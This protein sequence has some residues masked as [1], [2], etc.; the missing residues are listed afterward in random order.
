MK[1][2]LIGYGKMGRA[3]EEAAMQRNHEIIARFDSKHKLDEEI[4]ELADVAIEFSRPELAL[5]HIHACLENKIPVVVGTTGWYEDLKEVE[6][7][8][9]KNK[10]GVFHATNFSLGVNLFFQMN[11]KLAKLMNKHLEYA[12][13][14]EEIH[15]TQKL[16]APSGTAI[17]LAEHVIKKLDDKET[18]V[19]HESQNPEELTI[20]SKRIENV[21]GTHTV[22]YTSAVDSI[23]VTHTAFN[24]K[25]FAEGAVL[26]AEYLVGKTGIHTMDDLLKF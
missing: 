7:A 22:S 17:T 5:D 1:I 24:R 18:W 10:T 13:K 25:G 23:E 19:N 26:A 6:K 4:L 20:I 16:D 8:S 9:K 12:V 14:I 2:A 3:I 11:R 15:H 21:P